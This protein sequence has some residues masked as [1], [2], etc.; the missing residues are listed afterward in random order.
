MA[1]PIGNYGGPDRDYLEQQIRELR[2]GMQAL[3][4]RGVRQAGAMSIKAPNGHITFQT[5]PYTAFPMPDGSPQWVTVINDVNGVSRFLLWDDDTTTGGFT[6]MLLLADHLGNHMW[7]TDPVGG[8]DWPGQPVPLSMRFASASVA[9]DAASIATNVSERILWI[10]ETPIVYPYAEVPGTW[11]AASGTNTTRY[12]LKFNNVTVGTWD[13]VG[14]VGAT[15]G[16]FDIRTVAPIGTG[17]INTTITAQSLSGSGAFYCH[18]NCV[19][20]RGSP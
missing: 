17:S 10:G 6:Q 16:P 8:M 18:P 5:G 2:A 15:Q 7:R 20:L 1:S 3:Q 19:M 14:L 11:G 4:E 12:R 9:G 13:V